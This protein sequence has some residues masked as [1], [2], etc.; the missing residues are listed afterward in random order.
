MQPSSKGSGGIIDFIA[1]VRS[2]GF[3]T[4]LSHRGRRIVKVVAVADRRDSA[5]KRG[6]TPEASLRHSEPRRPERSCG[7]YRR[8]GSWIKLELIEMNERFA[9]ALRRAHPDPRE[10]GESASRWARGDRR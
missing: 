1:P 4:P 3:L 6:H 9:T 7:A 10:W 8:E 5:L 2:R